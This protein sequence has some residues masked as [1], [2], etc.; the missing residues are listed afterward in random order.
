VSEWATRDGCGAAASSTTRLCGAKAPVL[1]Y[2]WNCGGVREVVV[3]YNISNL[4]HVWPSTYA[5]EDGA[6][7]TCFDATRVVVDFFAGFA[8]PAGGGG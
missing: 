4:G 5:N 8:L 1:R 3:H 7:T 2:A 6:R